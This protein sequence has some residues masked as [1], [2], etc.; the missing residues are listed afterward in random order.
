MADIQIDALDAIG[1]PAVTDLLVVE[2]VA[3][4]TAKATAEPYLR[5]LLAL[6]A[7][8]PSFNSK[9]LTNVADPSGAQDAA[10]K[11]SSEAVVTAARVLAALAAAAGDVDVNGQKIVDVGTPAA[12]TD[13]VNKTYA[14]GLI[15]NL[16]GSISKSIA[17]G[18]TITLGAGEHEARVLRLTGAA[19]SDVIVDFPATAG[20]V[21]TV[22]N[23]STDHGKMVELRAASGSRK[24]YIGPGA[25]RVITVINGELYAVDEKAIVIERTVSLIDAVGNNDETLCKLP[26]DVLVTRVVVWGETTVVGGTSALTIGTSTGGTQIMLS[27]SAPAADA[28]LGENPAQWGADMAANGSAFYSAATTLYLRNVVATADV[29][30]GSVRVTIIAVQVQR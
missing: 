27:Q 29:T 23:E 21:W 15:T 14:D 22:A 30:A 25:T 6:L 13:A 11:T 2:S 12:G 20:R 4:G 10:T 18:G 24:V 8:H 9:R 3:E 5:A 19:G 16:T 26:A 17:A 28:G 1:T 7:D